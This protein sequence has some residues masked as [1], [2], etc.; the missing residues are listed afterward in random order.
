MLVLAS[1]CASSIVDAQV[2]QG[3]KLFLTASI[4][5]SLPFVGQEI[6]LTYTLYFKDSA[7]KISNETAPLLRGLWAKETAPERYIKSTLTSVQ[8]EP[9]RN[10]VVKQFRLMPLQSGKITVSGYSFLCNLP[11][12]Q[13]ASGGQEG[14]ETRLRITAPDVVISARALPEPVPA[15]FTGAVGTFQLELSSDKQSIRAGEPLTL[16]LLL[17]GTGNLLTLKLPD[18]TLP[19]NFRQN[20]AE[21]TTTL[22]TNSLPTTGTISAS[23]VAWPQSGGDYQIPALRMAAFNPDTKQFSTLFSKPLSITV[24]PS[25]QG[26]TTSGAEPPI[27]VT[28]KNTFLSPLLIITAIALLFLIIRAAAIMAKRKQLNHAKSKDQ[29]DTD[30]SAANLKQELF[31]WLEKAGI[32]SPG[33]L[34][35]VELKNAL[36]NIGLSDEIQSELPAVLDSLDK[37]LYSPTGKKETRTPDSITAKVNTLLQALRAISGSR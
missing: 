25:A 28:E 14:A 31:G 22:K 8:G 26:T 7:P 1:A 2:D 9:F 13:T 16:K 6:L 12:D 37:I 32:T 5:N 29:A 33:G 15:E 19:A 27:T 17:S 3:K 10:A 23:I 21:I 20:P 35:R 18:I 36:Q 11:E 30:T 4:N 24:A 34:T